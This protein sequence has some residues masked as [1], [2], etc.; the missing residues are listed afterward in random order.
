MLKPE[1][2]T[3]RAGDIAPDFAL[4]K[5][6]RTSVHLTD[7]RGKPLAIVFIRGTW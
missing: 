4:S 1:S 5:A 6:D 2:D 7:Y 3:L